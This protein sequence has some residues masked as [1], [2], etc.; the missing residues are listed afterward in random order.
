[1]KA[2]FMKHG[3]VLVKDQSTINLLQELGV[4]ARVLNPLVTF[5]DG[6]E[7]ENV[8]PLLLLDEEV[9]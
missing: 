1:M 6:I 3:C 2:T 8:S 4:G 7:I 9:L 5:T